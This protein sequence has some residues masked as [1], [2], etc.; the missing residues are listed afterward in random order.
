MVEIG[1]EIKNFNNLIHRSFL[2]LK[3][4]SLVDEMTGNNG[5]ILF[6]LDKN[7]NK[8]ITQKNIETAFG[9]TRSTVSTVL[10]LME[11]KDLIRRTKKNDDSRVK[12][13]EITDKGNDILS[14]IRN[15][16]KDFEKNIIKNIS[17]EE[18]DSFMKCIKKMKENILEVNL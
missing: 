7:K 13:V 14:Q 10:S 11:K 4:L 1:L 17:K 12:I 5:H 3:T 16:I 18:L 2:N 6:Y 8:V 15:E 9:I